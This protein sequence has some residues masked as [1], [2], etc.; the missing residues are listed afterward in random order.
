M[1]H[2]YEAL[3]Q[4]KEEIVKAIDAGEPLIFETRPMA[5]DDLENDRKVIPYEKQFMVGEKQQ[6]FYKEYHTKWTILS[7][8]I[9][10]NVGNADNKDEDYETP[11]MR[12]L[13]KA[14]STI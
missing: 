12:L 6:L 14:L 3:S 9:L 2:V 10:K 5:F 4:N 11:G 13:K 1:K 7:N 8:L